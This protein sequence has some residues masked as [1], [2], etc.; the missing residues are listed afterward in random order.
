MVS[1]RIQ[2]HEKIEGYLLVALALG[3]ERTSPSRSVISGKARCGA[4]SLGGLK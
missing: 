4:A 1:N 2:A 3:D